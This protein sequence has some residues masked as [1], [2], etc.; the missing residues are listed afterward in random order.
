MLT[1]TL[2]IIDTLLISHEL[3]FNKFFVYERN[4]TLSAPES[5]YQVNYLRG[6]CKLTVL[7]CSVT[8]VTSSWI[9]KRLHEKFNDNASKNRNTYQERATISADGV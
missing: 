2:T 5:N 9:H 8:S 6:F 4:R 1:D 3:R 7:T